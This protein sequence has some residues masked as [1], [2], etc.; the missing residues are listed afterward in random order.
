MSVV[1]I[2]GHGLEV[3][4]IAGAVDAPTLVFLHEG[5]GSIAQWREFPHVLAA[6]TG[7]AAMIYS[8]YGYG[9]SDVLQAPRASDYLH[10]EALVVL[11]QLLQQLDIQQPLL[12][13]HSD[14]AS[15]ALIYAGSEYAASTTG[16]IAMAPHVFVEPQCA[17]GI[18]AARQNFERGD[19]AHRLA[20]Y[21]RDAA[22]TFYGWNDLWASPAFRQWNIEA[23]LPKIVCPVLTIQGEDDVYGTMAQLDAIAAQVSGPCTL[24]KLP[25]C[26]HVPFREQAQITQHASAQ[27]VTQVVASRK[28]SV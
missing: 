25:H 23:F 14:G 4:C 20:N 11:P 7:C 13:G 3:E 21:H 16:V 15:I 22:R 19:L 28:V 18:D 5:L 9:R 6:D 27:F 1:R 2:D 17:P 10:H 12:V 8:R 24:L 26:G